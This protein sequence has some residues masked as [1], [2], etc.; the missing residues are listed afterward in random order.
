[1]TC[2]ELRDDLPLYALGVLEEPEL[3]E[4]HEH[5][6]RRCSN[7][8]PA[9]R[10]AMQTNGMVFATVPDARPSPD[11]R[12]RLLAAAGERDIK[13]R[14][15]VRWAAMFASLLVAMIVFSM[16]E[17]TR[18]AEV[19]ELRRQIIANA[20]DLVRARAALELLTL[21]ETRQVL[22]GTSEQQPPSGRVF[23]HPT[24]GV[25]LLAGN[26]PQLGP[27]KTYEMWVIPKGGTPRPAGLF[28]SSAS[29]RAVHVLQEPVDVATLGA[30]AVTVE[31][32]AGSAQPTTTP[33]IVAPW[34]I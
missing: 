25:L 28:N 31:P 14:G 16:K 7:C 32:E 33:L 11:L 30:V 4:V 19:A 9:L 15:W 6:A 22:F 10:E 13:P 1:M 5:L 18:R 27:G 29:R 21:P 24:R 2:E 17:R 20:E 8:T 26:L 34:S 12:A 23:V 3:S